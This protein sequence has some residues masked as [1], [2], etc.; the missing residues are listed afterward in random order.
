[1]PPIAGISL[2]DGRIAGLP[3]PLLYL[4]TV[5]LVLIVWAWRL[6][7]ALHQHVDAPVAMEGSEGER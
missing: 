7:R 5:W 6:S 3:V 4:F 2:I 1:M